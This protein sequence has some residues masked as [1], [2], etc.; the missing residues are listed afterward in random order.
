MKIV[1][2]ALLLACMP[3]AF[4]PCGPNSASAQQ[5]ADQAAYP[6]RERPL[7]AHWRFLRGDA[8]GAELPQFDDAAWRRVDLPHDWS[9]EDLPPRDRDPLFATITLTPGEWRFS[10]GDDPARSKPGFDD[11]AW[12][13]VH[14]PQSW[15]RH[16]QANGGP[17][18]FSGKTGLGW[19][20]RHFAV[21]KSVAGKTVF[22]EMGVI[23]GQNWTYVDGVKVQETGDDYWSNNSVMTRSIELPPAQATPGDHVVAVK[24]K[25]PP[26]GGF[27]PISIT[28]ASGVP[29]PVGP[30]PCDPGRSAGNINTGYAVGGIGWY[31]QHFTLPASD[32]GKQVRVVFD[33]SYMETTVW[34]NGVAVGSNHY[35]YSPFGLDLT[36]RLKPAGEENVLAVKVVNQGSNSRWYSGSGLFRPVYLE[37]TNRLRVAPW[38]LAVSTARVFFDR[39]SGG[40]PGP[41]QRG[42]GTS[43]RR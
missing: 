15:D 40:A 32:E 14:L 30:S 39:Q 13:T 10:S 29:K 12:K 21:P 20:R 18:S 42:R 1:M 24:I 7:N 9:I 41:C 5:V 3:V 25:G 22:I 6:L 33:G 34:L 2:A 37:V 35:G 43:Q 16:G 38:G 4:T 17:V 8:V 36:R 31:R 26:R 11:A 27:S 23:N 19:Y 28:S